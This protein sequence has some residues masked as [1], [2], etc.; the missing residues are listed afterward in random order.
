LLLRY[1]IRYFYSFPFFMARTPSPRPPRTRAPK[2]ANIAAKAS[3]TVETDIAVETASNPEQRKSSISRP[4][5]GVEKTSSGD[6]Y[7]ELSVEAPVNDTAGTAAITVGTKQTPKAKAAAGRAQ[8]QKPAST[9]TVA[10]RRPVAA[11]AAIQ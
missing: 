3:K 7:T 8:A 6:A 4:E 10:P 11:Q 2:V 1:L 9:K 5:P